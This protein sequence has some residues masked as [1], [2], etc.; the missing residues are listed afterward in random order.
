MAGLPCLA[1]RLCSSGTAARALRIDAAAHGHAA[2]HTQLTLKYI[3]MLPYTLN[4]KVYTREAALP[5]ALQ[6]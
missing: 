3:D 6:M 1:D 4:F 5:L 2:V